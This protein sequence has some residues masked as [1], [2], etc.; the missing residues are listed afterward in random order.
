MSKHGVLIDNDENCD[1][2]EDKKKKNAC[3]LEQ[4]KCA[5]D[6]EM[7]K[8]KKGTNDE[9]RKNEKH[10]QDLRDDAEKAYLMHEKM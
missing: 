7:K 5:V 4:M 1:E 6:Q 9:G 8:I 10:I 2:E 3:N